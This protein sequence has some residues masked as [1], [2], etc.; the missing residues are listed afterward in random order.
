MKLGTKFHF[1]YNPSLCEYI[2]HT[3]SHT[4]A[5]YRGQNQSPNIHIVDNTTRQHLYFI[6][7]KLF[8]CNKVHHGTHDY[9]LIVK[10]E[11]LS[12][13][14]YNIYVCFL[15]KV[16]EKEIENGEQGVVLDILMNMPNN[17][18]LEN[19]DIS[20]FI[21]ESNYSYHVAREKKEDIPCIVVVFPTYI[22]VNT[23]EKYAPR[24]NFV[25]FLLPLV[26][27][28]DKPT[29][30]STVYKEGFSATEIKSDTYYVDKENNRMEC[31]LYNGDDNIPDAEFVSLPVGEMSVG[32][33]NISIFSNA[34]L[35]I[36]LL[37]IGGVVITGFHFWFRHIIKNKIKIKNLTMFI[38]ITIFFVFGGGT[39]LYFVFNNNNTSAYAIGIGLLWVSY[40]CILN[41]VLANSN[42]NETD[43]I[44]KKLTNNKLPPQPITITNAPVKELG[45]TVVPPITKL[46]KSITDLEDKANELKNAS[47]ELFNT[48]VSTK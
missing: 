14:I 21:T 16:K 13:A 40:T 27:N 43:A 28:V 9:E 2:T 34:I 17:S 1:Q 19:V 12:N 6:S 26:K 39:Y 46:T 8:I 32:R 25:P 5:L 45:N 35:V 41:V 15:L 22:H 4:Q 38:V 36:F 24:D 33:Y 37:F 31:E 20:P 42:F 29:C 18:F 3:S 47:T 10:H 44:S 7:T 11:P 23:K 48:V 30:S